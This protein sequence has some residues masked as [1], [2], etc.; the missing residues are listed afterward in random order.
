MFA[1]YSGSLT[2]FAQRSF[3]EPRVKFSVWIDAG[4]T[5]NPSTPDDNQNFGRLLRRSLGTSR[6]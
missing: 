6:S 4:I 2:L 5:A 3:P 1:G